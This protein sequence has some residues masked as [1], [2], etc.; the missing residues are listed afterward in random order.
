V[1]LVYRDVDGWRKDVMLYN[2]NNI[3][4]HAEKYGILKA[5]LSVNMV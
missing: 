3:K 1:L 4:L 2:M 5:V